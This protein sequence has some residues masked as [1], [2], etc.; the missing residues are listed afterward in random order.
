MGVLLTNFVRLLKNVMYCIDIIKIKI[1]CFSFNFCFNTPTVW[2][3]PLAR[4]ENV[5]KTISSLGSINFK[6]IC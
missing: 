3:R 4:S 5:Y 6:N 2:N 1:R